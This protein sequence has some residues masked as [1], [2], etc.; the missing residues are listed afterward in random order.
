MIYHN[1]SDIK[2]GLARVLATYQGRHYGW[3]L[4]GGAF[5]TDRELAKH[6]ARI[7]DSIMQRGVEQ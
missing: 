2:I 3:S 6:A 1:A 4:P 7:M 5:T